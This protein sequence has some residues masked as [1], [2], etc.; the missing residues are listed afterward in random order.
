M[1]KIN[2]T[3]RRKI[4]CNKFLD[5]L[6]RG[7]LN[8]EV[9]ATLDKSG[10]ISREYI[11]RDIITNNNILYA[12]FFD[13]RNYEIWNMNI[14]NLIREIELEKIVLVNSSKFIENVFI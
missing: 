12:K 4:I 3:K 9:F 6:I 10:N 7:D 8:N 5:L 13:R 2:F 14:G 11:L 1:F